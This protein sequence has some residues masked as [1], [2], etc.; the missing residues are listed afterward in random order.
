MR[1]GGPLVVSLRLTRTISSMPAALSRRDGRNMIW[2]SVLGRRRVSS[3]AAVSY[4][5]DLARQGSARAGA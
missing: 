4:R 2:D 1:N 5:K 3:L